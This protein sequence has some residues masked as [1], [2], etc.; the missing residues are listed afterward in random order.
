MKLILSGLSLVGAAVARSAS[1]SDT[2]VSTRASSSTHYRS[3]H[4]APTSAPTTYSKNNNYTGVISTLTVTST[5]V[6][7]KRSFLALSFGL[8]VTSNSGR[9]HYHHKVGHSHRNRCPICHPNE[10]INLRLGV[11][12]DHQ[13]HSDPRIHSNCD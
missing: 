11:H 1:V 2:S 10:H 12:R 7:F 5:E 6:R 4:V 8:T 13:Q 9:P 3:G